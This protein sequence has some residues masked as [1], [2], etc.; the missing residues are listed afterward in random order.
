MS[1]KNGRGRA[2]RSRGFLPRRLLGSSDSNTLSLHASRLETL[3]KNL[4]GMAYR[5]LNLQ[6][7]PMDFVSQ[8]C[9]ELCGYHPEEIESQQVLWGDFTH[10][11]DVGEVDRIVRSATLSGLA[12]EVEYRII[13]KDGTEKWVWERGRPVDT[14]Q[15]GVAILEGLITDITDHKLSEAALV[16]AKAYSDAVVES[17]AEGIITVDAKG[18]IE[19]FNLAAQA[20]F[21]Y[22]PDNVTGKHCSI[23]FDQKYHALLVT[24]IETQYS[25]GSDNRLNLEAEGRKSDDNRFPM[26]FSLNII[27]N[28][29]KNKYVILVRDLT[30]RRAAENEVRKQ[31]DIL[32]HADR[33]NTLGEMAAAIAHEINQPLTAL[34]MYAKSG[35]TFLDQGPSMTA[36]LRKALMG[37]ST[38]A[39]RAGVIMERTRTM[40]RLS[41]SVR[42]HIDIISLLDDVFELAK[43]EARIRCFQIVLNV[44]DNLPEILCDTIQIQQV[45]LNLLRNGMESMTLAGRRSGSSIEL[46][47]NITEQGVNIAIE[48]CGHGISTDLSVKL[49]EPFVTTK[50]EGM[51]LG[52]SISRSI[53]A[54]HNGTLVHRNNRHG[55]ATFSFCLRRENS[56]SNS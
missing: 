19:S 27:D 20:I 24:F 11:D 54:S 44:D 41:G 3:L 40:T 38:Q 31:R 13:A 28:V 1:D 46:R 22:T 25:Q 29:A 18:H 50:P 2:V 5:C 43:V 4:P 47:A 55:G 32:A 45:I 26:Q 30:V 35:L 17:A 51:G 15:D 16:N 56:N 23:L 36:N 7:W 42:E 14:R 12:F 33:L 10:P 9:F 53:V 8:G 37:I 39:H 34:S 21:K 49:Y 52:L 6:H 48:D